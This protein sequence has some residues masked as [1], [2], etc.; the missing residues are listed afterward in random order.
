MF[1][2]YKKE[3]KESQM[4]LKTIRDFIFKQDEVVRLVVVMKDN[5]TL[6]TDIFLP[7]TEKTSIKCAESFMR[8]AQIENKITLGGITYKYDD[9]KFYYP[10][11][12]K[13]TTTPI[14]HYPTYYP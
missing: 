10:E 4:K 7:S 3:Y 1:Y 14:Y 8:A 11:K 5:N 13:C 2:N 6:H 9:V 12:F